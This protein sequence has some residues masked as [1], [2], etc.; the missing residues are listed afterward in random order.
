MMNGKEL[1]MNVKYVDLETWHMANATRYNINER[2]RPK[3]LLHYVQ[4]MW[5]LHIWLRLYGGFSLDILNIFQL[6]ENN[7]NKGMDDGIVQR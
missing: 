3:L 2:F 6:L 4:W 7:I 5:V 1:S